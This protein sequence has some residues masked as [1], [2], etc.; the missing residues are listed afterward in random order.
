MW[1]RYKPKTPI[2]RPAKLVLI[3]LYISSDAKSA[4]IVFVST[5]NFSPG[6]KTQMGREL[7]YGN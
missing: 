7:I 4:A 2:L 6:E 5:L 1:Q 3:L